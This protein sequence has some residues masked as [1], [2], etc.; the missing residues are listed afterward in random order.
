MTKCP[1]FSN[2]STSPAKPSASTRHPCPSVGGQPVYVTRRVTACPGFIH[3]TSWTR[4]SLEDHGS[5]SLAAPA[6]GAAW[7]HSEG[8]F[9]LPWCNEWSSVHGPGLYIVLS[10]TFPRKPPLIP[11]FLQIILAVAAHIFLYVHCVI[12]QKSICDFARQVPSHYAII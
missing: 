3:G 5:L 9:Q 12:V 7:P 8:S 11:S 2:L 4:M 6:Q 1:L 10:H